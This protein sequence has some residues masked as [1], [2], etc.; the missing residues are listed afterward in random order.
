MGHCTSLEC[1]RNLTEGTLRQEI[2][3]E[4]CISDLPRDKLIDNGHNN[5]AYTSAGTISAVSCS[6]LA[7]GML[8]LALFMKCWNP[9]KAPVNHA[10]QINR[11][12]ETYIGGN[13]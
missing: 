10:F 9:R 6:V 12:D 11:N 2:L 5:L 3:F 8:M 4:I 1:C 7:A 13:L